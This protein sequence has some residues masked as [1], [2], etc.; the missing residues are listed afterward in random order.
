MGANGNLGA[1]YGG[2]G[3]GGSTGGHQGGAG[4]Q[5]LVAIYYVPI[6]DP[7]ISSLSINT[8]SN[9]GGYNITI[10]GTEYVY[11]QSV[12][13]GANTASFTAT[14]CTSITATVPAAAT[15]GTVNLVVTNKVGSSSASTFTYLSDSTSPFL[16]LGGVGMGL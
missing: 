13:F 9:K 16:L 11:V 15:G 3:G 14:S 2:G 6:T 4:A 12:K 1:A 8:G 5:G 7:T 10:T